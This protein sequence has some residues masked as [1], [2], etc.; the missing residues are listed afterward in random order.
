MKAAFL[1]ALILFF[2]ITISY[3]GATAETTDDDPHAIAESDTAGLRTKGLVHDFMI[4]LFPDESY[5]LI[6]QTDS[7]I[8]AVQNKLGKFSREYEEWLWR[9]IAIFQKTERFTMTKPLLDTLASIYRHTRQKSGLNR[10]NESYS[11]YYLFT[12][13]IDEAYK[14]ARKSLKYARTTEQILTAIKTLRDISEYIDPRETIRWCKALEPYLKDN[15]YS[16]TYISN[17]DKWFL[18]GGDSTRIVRKTKA[19]MKSAERLNEK[20]EAG[21]EL[22]YLT[23]YND[24]TYL[25][26]IVQDYCRYRA[27][28][29]KSEQILISESDMLFLGHYMDALTELARYYGNIGDRLKSITYSEEI[30]RMFE[31]PD[32][33]SD[34]TKFHE[35]RFAENHNNL[36]EYYIPALKNLSLMHIET[37]IS[38]TDKRE[39]Y[40]EKAFED[41]R[42]ILSAY[43]NDIGY[44]TGYV[45]QM[46]DYDIKIYLSRYYQAVQDLYYM[47][48]DINTIPG[49]EDIIRDR[50]ALSLFYKGLL[51]RK[52]RLGS[53]VV[54]K[55]TDVF[56]ADYLKSLLKN[57]PADT[58]FIDFIYI[59]ELGQYQMSVCSSNMECPVSVTADIFGKDSLMSP[60]IYSDAA[61]YDKIWG[62]LDGICPEGASIYFVPDRDLY[63]VNIEMLTDSSGRHAYE[64]YRLHRLTSF[65]ELE[66][67]TG[68][69]PMKTTVIFGNPDLKNAEKEIRDIQ[70][71]LQ[72]VGFHVETFE[73]GNAT[74]SAFKK[75]AGNS[76]DII[77]F[78][79]HGFYFERDEYKKMEQYNGPEYYDMSMLNS[80]LRM[81]RNISE[82]QQHDD[83]ILLAE[84]IAGLD[85][86]S[87]GLAV[88]T[89]CET[90]LGDTIFDGVLGLQRAF[91]IAGV[92]TLILTLWN[93]SD[94]AASLFSTSFYS[95]L[96]KGDDKR[97]S[98]LKAVRKVQEKYPEPYYWA[99]FIMID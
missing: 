10:L 31:H 50:L 19:F 75:L 56:S 17:M 45:R 96:T 55:D 9:Q 71:A 68:D 64:K 81:S 80:G 15:K 46:P 84:E 88:L 13:S 58:Y 93:V 35:Y 11:Y 86:G 61:I 83:G 70:S 7:M 18:A 91:K 21:L 85:L 87:T 44:I 32:R 26:D 62:K 54:D 98:F 8:N 41:I 2:G 47:T 27:A 16:G 63:S 95:C 92:Q 12:G 69:A 72:S 78:S 90:G 34:Y 48:S 99:P 97:T 82:E 33:S 57:F 76:P 53:A 23:G 49:T 43:K 20:S 40:A 24:T 22:W 36:H 73:K 30:I 25:H 66:N 1:T 4:S 65:L 52:N 38:N 89:C 94:N 42:K 28:R 14:A 39:E 60:Q 29:M 6:D 37:A 74:E 59:E 5:G 79:T 67:I 3:A 51:L 77:H